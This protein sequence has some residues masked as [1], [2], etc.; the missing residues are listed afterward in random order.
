MSRVVRTPQADLD[1]FEIAVYIAQDNVEAAD[2]F[3]EKLDR[4]LES[5]SRSSGMGR[6]R[7]EL[8]AGLRSFPFDRYVIFYKPLRG[9]IEVVRVLHASRDI[10]AIFNP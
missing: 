5:L 1:V 9:G 4:K 3:L 7:D 2:R 10:P 8:V 6:I